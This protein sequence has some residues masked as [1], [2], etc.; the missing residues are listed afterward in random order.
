MNVPGYFWAGEV[1]ICRNEVRNCSF[2]VTFSA[3]CNFLWFIWNGMNNPLRWGSICCAYYLWTKV[4]YARPTMGTIFYLGLLHWDNKQSEIYLNESGW[5]W[6]VHQGC[7]KDY[8][9][10]AA[11]LSR[12]THLRVIVN[13][14]GAL[15]QTLFLFQA[16]Q[17]T[18][19]IYQTYS[20]SSAEAIAGLGKLIATA[21]DGPPIPPGRSDP[22]VWVCFSRHK[23]H[24]KMDRSI[25][26]LKSTHEHL[27]WETTV[28]LNVNC[29]ISNNPL[30]QTRL[31]L[32]ICMKY[33]S[34]QANTHRPNTCLSMNFT[35]P[36][37]VYLPLCQ[38]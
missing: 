23:S 35:C 13:V 14:A 6:L 33:A 11:T 8:L 28:L 34:Y 17:T 32:E 10:W 20:I 36:S 12:P 1:Y 5:V 19:W 9:L 21:N 29:K 37:V 3:F 22:Y 30:T 2:T 4:M 26:G 15:K 25:K 27:L 24:K 18:C 38:Y 16:T 7:S 31:S